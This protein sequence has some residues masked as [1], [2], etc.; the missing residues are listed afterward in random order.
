MDQNIKWLRG[1]FQWVK[2][3]I[4]IVTDKI[5]SLNPGFPENWNRELEGDLESISGQLYFTIVTKVRK[6]S[7]LAFFCLAFFY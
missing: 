7:H 1:Q 5:P 6:L 2:Q 4:T 3:L